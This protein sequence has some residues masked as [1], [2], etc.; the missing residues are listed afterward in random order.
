MTKLTARRLRVSIGA[1][2]PSAS[3]LKISNV[4]TYIVIGPGQAV[5]F[6]S[7]RSPISTMVHVLCLDYDK[8]RSGI[9]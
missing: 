7:L 1:A 5:T 8:A 2:P 3:K 6:L 4:G 9:S